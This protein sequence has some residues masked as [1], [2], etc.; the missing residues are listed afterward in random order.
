[1]KFGNR[2]NIALLLKYVLAH[3]AKN[4]PVVSKVTLRLMLFCLYRNATAMPVFSGSYKLD[5]GVN[6][7][8]QE[9]AGGGGWRLNA[10]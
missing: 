1:M 5:A 10:F 2:F 6:Q 8:G 3:V 4:A 7:A 9:C